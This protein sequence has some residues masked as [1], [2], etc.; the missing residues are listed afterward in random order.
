[1]VAA[2]PTQAQVVEFLTGKGTFPQP[3]AAKRH[4]WPQILQDD[5]PNKSCVFCPSDANVRTRVSY[6]YKYAND[7]AWRDSTLR[8]R[9][10]SDYGYEHDQIAF[11]EHAGWH[12]GDAAGIKN[13]VKINVSYMDTH[14]ATIT[15]AHGPAGYTPAA[16]ERTGASARLG[17]PMYFD[18]RVNDPGPNTI[19][20]P[21][22]FIDPSTCYD[23][24]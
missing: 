16:D 2:S 11:Y 22:D 7:L 9:K 6:W 3:P 18:V 5:L 20:D 21:A 24:P 8:R 23:M 12:V 13:G 15:V 19:H 4:T 17:E 10:A 14:T 1:M